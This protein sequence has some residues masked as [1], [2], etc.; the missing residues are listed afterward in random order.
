MQDIVGFLPSITD[1]VPELD[2]NDNFV[3]I[4]SNMV[5]VTPGPP[6][7]GASVSDSTL[8]DAAMSKMRGHGEIVPEV[9]MYDSVRN[10]SVYEV[11]SHQRAAPQ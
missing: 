1:A 11:E 8:I 10:G 7:A 5:I 2:Q 9:M 6:A 4:P 3:S